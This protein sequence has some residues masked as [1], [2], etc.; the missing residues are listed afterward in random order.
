MPN[1][2]IVSTGHISPLAAEV[3]GRF[4]RIE[5][6][7]KTDEKS[8]ISLMGGTIALLVR[9]VT[10][11]SAN[12][13]ESAHDLQVIGRTGTGYENVDIAAATRCGIPVVFT[14]GAGARSVAEGAMAMILSLV[15]RMPELDRKTRNGEWNSR[16][17]LVIGDLHGAVLGI[18]GL[19][20]IG[21]EVAH[22]ARAF[23]MRIIA[24]DP[25]ISKQGVQPAG[26]ELVELNEL[27]K[28]SDVISIHAPLTNE[29]RGMLDRKRIGLIKKGAILVNLA[30]GGLMES[31]DVIHEALNSGQLAAVGLDVYPTE[32]PDISHPIFSHPNTMLSPH[33]MGLSVKSSE[34]IFSMAS[35]GMAE[36]L[37]GRIPPNVVN[38]EVFT[39]T[40]RGTR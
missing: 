16:D 38:P 36:V 39:S 14:P 10:Q 15:K 12:V 17:K 9:G 35:K 22:L 32:P 19:G 2:R 3:L 20:R 5:V 31:L 21:R 27:L 18:I 24:C 34:A 25:V 26:V 30:R 6:A 23:D 37:E 13:I 28:T 1:H 40:L 7:P 4:G 29:T 33:A 8:L 11:I